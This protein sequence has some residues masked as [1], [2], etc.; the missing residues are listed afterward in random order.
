VLPAAIGRGWALGGGAAFLVLCGLT[1]GFVTDDA[2]I[3]ARYAENLASGDG[4][5]WNPG[6]ERVEGFSNPLL[7]VLEALVH[8]AGGSAIAAAR[9]V[10]IASGLGLVVLLWRLAPPAVGVVAA[11][12]GL[13][14]CALCAPLALWGVGGLETLPA[15][16]ALTAGV[17]LLVADRPRAPLLAGAA[18]AVLPWLRPEGLGV[19]LA[20][21]VLAEGPGLLR[22]ARRASAVRRLALAAGLPLASQALLEIARLAAYGHL[23]PNSAIYKSGRGMTTDVLE[24]FVLQSGPVLALAACGLVVARGRQRL[25]AVPVLVYAAGSVG[26]LNSVNSF[27]RLMLPAWPTLAL[28]AGVAV[29][30]AHRRRPRAAL[31]VAAVLVAWT[32]VLAWPVHR[33]AAAYAACP[34]DARLEAAAWLRAHT[35]RGTVYSVSDAGL[36]PLR[37]GERVAVDQLRLN[38]AQLQRTGR[39]PLPQEIDLVY[40]ARPQVLVL[41]STRPDRLAGRYAADRTMTSDPRFSEYR[42]AHVAGGGADC[43]YSLFLYRLR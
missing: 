26:M 27:S 11:P 38:E 3:T 36:L 2:W 15:V 5:A 33:F 25:L 41:A 40:D 39:L 23:L 20:V 31:A 42:L 30:A 1:W 14:L 4:F 12:V 19:A 28:L 18:L 8:R 9:V 37:A 6:G 43:R 32:A 10:G 22:R 21:V 29:A 34:Q 35:P 16:L 13:L 24:R 17:L 7:F